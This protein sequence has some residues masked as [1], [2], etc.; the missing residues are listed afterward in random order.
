MK[1][2][3]Q[4]VILIGAGRYGNGLVGKKYKEGKIAGRVCA[5]VDPNISQISKSPD[6][7]FERVP[8][9][10]TFEKVSPNLINKNT[11]AE[12][13]TLPSSVPDIFN[14]L[15]KKG[16]KK[17]ILPK[18]VTSNLDVYKEMMNKVK[19]NNV[20]TA[21]ASNWHYSEITDL[22]KELIEK[23]QGKRKTSIKYKDEV[24]LIPKGLDIERV[25]VEYS[26]KKEKL[27][28]APPSQELPHAIQI[29]YSL[30][31]TDFK[32][33][34]PDLYISKQSKSRVN[35]EYN[36][37]KGI[38]N[39]IEINS[40]LQK[41]DLENNKRERKL[42]IYLNDDDPDP[43]ITADYDVDFKDGIC[44]KPGCVSVDIEKNGKRTLWYQHIFEDNLETMYKPI[45]KY[46][47]TGRKSNTL[48]MKDYLPVIEQISKAQDKW[49]LIV[50]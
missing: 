3:K 48:N 15:I 12:I 20:Q 30:G 32:N 28:T 1:T 34:E 45:F 29:L 16:I 14:K 21:I 17:I 10:E 46:F 26:K 49:D 11:V 7:N 36:N 41:D 5:V 33:Q 13:A 25:E 43:D 44:T 39:G 9:F 18:P 22:T 2:D 38:K 50:K 31:L 27:D 37:I 40:D 24:R 35:V 8:G 47:K 4:N 19:K 42:K 6:Y 23:I